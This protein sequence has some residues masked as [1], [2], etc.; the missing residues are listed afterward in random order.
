M[1]EVQSG[2]DRQNNAPIMAQVNETAEETIEQ[3]VDLVVTVLTNG[4][5]AE[6]I[7]VQAQ[8]ILLRDHRRR[9]VRAGLHPI[10]GEP[11]D[12]YRT[13]I[14]ENGG[15]HPVTGDGVAPEAQAT[16]SR[17]SE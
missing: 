11:P 14:N 15:K 6:P 5:F 12:A 3:L 4:A 2:I 13:R 10:T 17:R 7:R 1:I 8:E 9:N 16:R